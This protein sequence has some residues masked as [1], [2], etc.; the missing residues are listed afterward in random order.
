MLVKRIIL[1]GQVWGMFHFVKNLKKELFL[2]ENSFIQEIFIG[3]NSVSDVVFMETTV[4]FLLG[5]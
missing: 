3:H 1:L 5:F 2:K 4:S